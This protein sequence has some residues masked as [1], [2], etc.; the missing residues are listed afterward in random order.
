MTSLECDNH[1]E[2]PTTSGPISIAQT[3][4][5]WRGSVPRHIGGRGQWMTPCHTA[6]V[7]SHSWRWRTS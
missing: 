2:E 5:S 7:R 4:S 6:G 3:D 1:Q